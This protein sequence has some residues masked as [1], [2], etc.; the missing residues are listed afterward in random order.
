MHHFGHAENTVNAAS[1]KATT[2]MITW[3]DVE[4]ILDA[5]AEGIVAFDEQQRVIGLNR[6]ACEILDADKQR[7]TRPTCH[8]LFAQRP[9]AATSATASPVETSSSGV[10][11]RR[12]PADPREALEREL[13]ATGWNVSRTAR[14]LQL[15]RTAIY[16][17]IARFGLKRP[18]D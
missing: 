1:D 8:A 9:L 2:R 16:Q 10:P 4:A 6:A 17:Q 14:R 13:E 5:L 12:A 18:Q 3:Q 11:I 7:A 15:S